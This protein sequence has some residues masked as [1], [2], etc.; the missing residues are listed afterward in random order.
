MN[1]NELISYFGFK[2]SENIEINKVVTNSKEA[3]KNSIFL[4]TKRNQMSP[5]IFAS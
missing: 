3:D 1:A 4:A 2:S 5:A